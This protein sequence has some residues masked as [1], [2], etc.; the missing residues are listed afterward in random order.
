[1]ARPGSSPWCV[2][3]Y[4][5]TAGIVTIKDIL[6]EI[7]GEI[8]E[9]ELPDETVTRVDDGTLLVSGSMAI[10]DFNEAVDTS[11]PRRGANDGRP[12]V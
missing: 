3:E 11:L 4:G 5:G 6:E 9:C 12:G 8:A 7:V 10:D 2:D 1:M